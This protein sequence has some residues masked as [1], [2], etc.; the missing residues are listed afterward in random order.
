[1]YKAVDTGLQRAL[2]FT[3]EELESN[4]NGY[5]TERQQEIL[6]ER[7]K[8]RGCGSRLAVIAFVISAGMLVLAPL[9]VGKSAA[10]SGEDAFRQVLPYTLPVAGVVVGV[11]L[12]FVVVGYV[13]SRDLDSGKVSVATGEARLS[14]RYFLKIHMTG[15]Y[16]T[17]GGTR[18]QVQK[19]EFDAFV[20]GGAYRIYYV[21][22][23]P[24]GVILSVERWG[25]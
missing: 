25:A 9:L 1:M 14:T 24:V 15:Y 2:G 21:K 5:L 17:V 12:L 19:G 6:A 16:V 4:R 10:Q 11:A 20:E 7:R 18:F 3:T 8:L 22:Y 13:R 23:P